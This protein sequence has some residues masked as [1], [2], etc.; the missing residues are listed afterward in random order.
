MGV[1][2]VAGKLASI[3]ICAALT[4]GLIYAI[5]LTHDERQALKRFVGNARKRLHG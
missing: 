1:E 5:G 4:V 2:S 3:S